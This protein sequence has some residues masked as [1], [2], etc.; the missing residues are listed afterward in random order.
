ML[1]NASIPHIWTTTSL[2]LQAA[3]TDLICKY[4]LHEI[5][6]SITSWRWGDQL[7]ALAVQPSCQTH[8]VSYRRINAW[9]GNACS[10]YTRWQQTRFTAS[11]FSRTCK[12]Q[13]LPTFSSFSWTGWKKN[14]SPCAVFLFEQN[15]EHIRHIR[16]MKTQLLP[17]EI[18]N[19]FQ[20]AHSIIL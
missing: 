19:L 13:N 4:V 8:T 14:P 6:L 17:Q 2:S 7:H 16:Q 1:I 9:S 18:Y 11:Q 12:G 5:I 15:H 10:D 20:T 3:Q